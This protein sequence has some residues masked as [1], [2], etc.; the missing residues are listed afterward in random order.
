MTIEQFNKKITD[1][2][3][4]VRHFCILSGVNNNT[5]KQL[6]APSLKDTDGKKRR[7]RELAEL[8]R[9][10]EY[11]PLHEIITEKE[12]KSLCAQL[13]TVYGSA[14]KFRKKYPQIPKST[15][16]DLLRGRTKTK[17][18]AYQ[19]ILSTIKEDKG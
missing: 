6:T 5:V 8:A 3:G 12:R 18:Q 1:K 9:N 19:V 4:S 2:F 11:K 7:R 14:Y 15:L 10:T 13:N 17:T 16:Y